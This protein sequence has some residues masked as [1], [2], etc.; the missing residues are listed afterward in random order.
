MVNLELFKDLIGEEYSV[1]ELSNKLTA[2]GCEDICEF[3]NWSEIIE[4]GDVVVAVDPQGDNH[5]QLFFEV[6]ILA[7]TTTEC[8]EASYIKVKD[9]VNF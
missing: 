7:D 1:I 5:I 3:G 9:I 2:L 6:T 8:I 4:S